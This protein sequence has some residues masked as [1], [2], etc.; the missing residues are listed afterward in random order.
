[1]ASKTNRIQFLKK[2]GLSEDTTLSLEDIATL[3][4]MPIMALQLSYNRG[5]GAWK[6]NPESVRMKTT[7][8]K[9][10]SAPRKSKLGPQQ[11]GMARAYAFAQKTKKV[12]Y[13]ADND[14]REYFGLD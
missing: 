5:I 1:M 14:I 4:G 13:G 12:Y 10:P 11:W 6:T 2:H 9:V 3:A 8:G 7:F